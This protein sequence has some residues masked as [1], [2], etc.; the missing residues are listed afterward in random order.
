[1]IKKLKLLLTALT[2]VTASTLPAT[3]D[4]SISKNLFLQRAF[5]ANTAR[6]LLMEGHVTLT[7]F[8]GFYSYLSITGAYQHSWSQTADKGMGAFPFW[9]GTNVMTIGTNDSNSS[10]DAYQFG[11]GDVTAN[12]SITLSPILYQGGADFLIYFGASTNDPGMFMKLKA[13]LGIIAINPQLTEVEATAAANYPAGALSVNTIPVNDPATTMT[14]AFAGNLS[15]G[16]TNYGD[17]LPMQFGLI[18]GK[19][20]SG[21]Q[22]GDLEMTLGYN[23]I[24]D[25]DYHAAIGLRA[26]APS[27]NKPTGEFLLQPVFG[28]GGSWTVGGYVDGKI[29]LWEDHANSSLTVNVMGTVLHWM[30]KTTTRSYDLTANGAGSKYLLVAD[31]SSNSYQGI[32]QNLVNLSTLES[33]SS[34]TAE[35]DASISLSYLSNGWSADFGYNFWGR[36]AETLSISGA[37]PTNRYAILG[38]QLVGEPGDTSDNANQLCQPSATISSSEAASTVNSILNT[39]ALLVPATTPSNRISGNSV[40]DVEAAQQ[41][42]ASTSKIFAKVGYSYLDSHFSPHI[43]LAGE[44]EISTSANNALPQWTVALI[45]GMYF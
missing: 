41:A 1:M 9:S 7:D 19:Q 17:F 39:N 18:N 4:L 6:E 11:L 45:G 24:C 5:S 37:F 32:V 13:P 34:L 36:T 10:L 15:G 42:S 27:A 38:R 35:G 23:F 25:E 28:R 33:Q 8:D 2:F 22:F 40:F 21:T 43:G 30:K 44:F 29:K 3:S 26:S 12:G 31:Y 20:S 14:Q 16:Q